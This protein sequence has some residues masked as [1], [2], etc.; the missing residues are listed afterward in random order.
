[1]PTGAPAVVFGLG[2]H[3]LIWGIL[4]AEVAELGGEE[5]VGMRDRDQDFLLSGWG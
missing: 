1:M 3:G 2:K 5:S 4:K